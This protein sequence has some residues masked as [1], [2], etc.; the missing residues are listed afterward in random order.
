MYKKTMN[1]IVSIVL[2][3]FTI[4]NSADS[5]FLLMFVTTYLF[6]KS[7]N[8]INKVSKM[9]EIIPSI[10]ILP[11]FPSSR[12]IDVGNIIKNYITMIKN[13]CL[14]IK[15]KDKRYNQF[16]FSR[17]SMVNFMIH[18]TR[19]QILLAPSSLTKLE[20]KVNKKRNTKVR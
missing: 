9:F 6:V 4:S 1:G 20:K 14:R 3:Q 15:R 7:S 11:N 10:E 12:G 19:L 18:Q 16:N 8:T 13:Y 2:V 17:A 5:K